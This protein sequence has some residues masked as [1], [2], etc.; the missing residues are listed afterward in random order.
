[1]KHSSNCACACVCFDLPD[2]LSCSFSIRN[3]SREVSE[4]NA[5]FA[6]ALQ[7][8]LE[9]GVAL[10]VRSSQQGE[11]ASECAR[12]LQGALRSNALS[13]SADQQQVIRC[14]DAIVSFLWPQNSQP[15]F[16]AD[17]RLV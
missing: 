5:R 10:R 17:C 15:G 12:Q 9:L 1:M 7:I 8:L 3:I 6:E 14:E 11:A 13:S 4:R 16:A 2:G